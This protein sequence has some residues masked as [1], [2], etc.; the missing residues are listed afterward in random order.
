MIDAKYK[1]SLTGEYH[2]GVTYCPECDYTPKLIGDC[3]MGFADSNI[4]TMAICECP[5]C[6]SKWRFHVRLDSRAMSYYD[7]MLLSIEN[8]TNNHFK[9]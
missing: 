4:G 1:I 5:K 7:M 9:D 2:R 3:I 8:G 6:F